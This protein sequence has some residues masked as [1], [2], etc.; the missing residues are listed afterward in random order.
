MTGFRSRL[1]HL[2]W[3]F[4]SREISFSSEIFVIGIRDV[5]CSSMICLI[6]EKVNRFWYIITGK[7]LIRCYRTDN[8]R[9]LITICYLFLS[10]NYIN[11]HCI[12]KKKL[13]PRLKIDKNSH[14]LRKRICELIRRLWSPQPRIHVHV[15]C[16]S[17]VYTIS[18]LLMKF[19]LCIDCNL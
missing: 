19:A 6:S 15:H 16:V 17:I 1:L 5:H 14:Y 10:I 12:D 7:L 11:V 8:L 2:W 3:N 13:H 4:A 9:I 18:S